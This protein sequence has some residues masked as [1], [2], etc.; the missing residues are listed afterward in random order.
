MNIPKTNI[1]LPFLIGP[2]LIFLILFAPLLAAKEAPQV[3][4]NGEVLK[5]VWEGDNGSIAAFKGV[6]FAAP[7]VGDLRWR[8]PQPHQPRK[9]PQSATE[10]A[11][12]CMQNDYLV[13]WYVGVATKMGHSADVVGRPNGVSEN[14]LYLNVWTPDRKPDQPLPVMVWVHGGSNK[15]GWSY[16]P[17]YIGKRLAAKGVV[18]VTIA[19]RVGP[20]GFFSHPKLE[21]GE[22]EPVANFGFLDAVHAFRWVKEHI[23]AFGG[24]PENITAF[25][26]SSGAG[27]IRDWLATEIA[28]LRLYHNAIAQS[29]AG[30]LTDR[31][32]LADEQ[33]TGE[34]MLAYLGFDN[35]DL[36]NEQLRAIPAQDI[37][38]AG[39]EALPGHYFD[40]VVDDLTFNLMPLESFSRQQMS[41]VNFLIGSNRDEWYMYYDPAMTWDDVDQWLEQRTPAQASIL[42]LKVAGETDVR[43]AFDRLTAAHDT[44]CPVRHIAA[45]INAVG[46]NAWVYYFTRQRPG[47][48]MK[49]LGVYHGT[50]IGYVF[51]EHEV[52]QP[53]DEVDEWLTDIVMD[54]WVQFART[55]N[56][57]VP[58]R[59]AWPRYT[60]AEP[61]VME[62]GDDVRVIPPHDADFCLWLGPR[63]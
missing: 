54:Y 62:L 60:V 10:F 19:Y 57:N 8:A 42:K 15:S 22:G 26:E 61:R 29:P 11:P 33:K 21:N 25:G 16:E 30:A 3:T 13:Q 38:R 27:D 58:G 2:F 5:G 47:D 28:E 34:A 4:A 56:P 36:D 17:N 46:G 7:P 32:T 23:R 59:P 35:E 50:E 20:F 24:D 43:R 1:R 55:G 52:W 9:G 63:R 39:V 18:V 44:H 53:T 41:N 48:A 45:S 40:V 51:N 12:G 6:P 49:N 31:R 37:V 14:C